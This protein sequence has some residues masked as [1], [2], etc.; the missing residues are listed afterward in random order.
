GRH[1][2]YLARSL[3]SEYTGT[4]VGSL[5]SKSSTLLLNTDSNSCYAESA[6][7]SYMLFV[8]GTTP[9]A[10]VLD[11]ERLRMVGD[12]FSVVQHLQVRLASGLSRG[13]FSA[14]HNGVL[15]YR[16]EANVPA[17]ELVWYDRHGK[18][19][20]TVGDPASY[21]NPA[22]SPDEKKLVVSREDPATGTRDLWLF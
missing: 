9:M 10:Q 12:P 3:Q 17:S 21:S 2:T 11:T 4:Y 6:G 16:T 15:V 19:L 14:S 5:D 20:G 8:T 18:R 7:T 1:F 13:S 22:L